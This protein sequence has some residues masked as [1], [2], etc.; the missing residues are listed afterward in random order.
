MLICQQQHRSFIYIWKNHLQKNKMRLSIRQRSRFLFL[1]LTL[2]LHPPWKSIMNPFY[3]TLWVSLCSIFKGTVRCEDFNLHWMGR[4]S[5]ALPQTQI[6]LQRESGV[7]AAGSEGYGMYSN[8]RVSSIMLHGMWVR[9]FSSR[10]K[11]TNKTP[12]WHKQH[13]TDMRKMPLE[14]RYSNQTTI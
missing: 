11:K 3:T 1:V 7:D 12:P 5:T 2:H 9:V 8:D 4:F 6:Q 13:K 14:L 10:G